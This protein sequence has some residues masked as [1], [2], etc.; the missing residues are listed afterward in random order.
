MSGWERHQ[1]ATGPILPSGQRMIFYT[2]KPPGWVATGKYRC[3]V[4]EHEDQQGNRAYHGDDQLPFSC[5]ADQWFN[6]PTFQGA[7]PG[8]ILV[9][10]CDQTTASSERQ[11]FGGWTPPNDNANEDSVA[12][13]AQ[14]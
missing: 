4:W 7:Y 6:N 5:Q 3:L 13:C 14:W 11:N 1:L 2:L 8:I 12:L 9:P 10:A